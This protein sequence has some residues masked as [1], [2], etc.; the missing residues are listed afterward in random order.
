NTRVVATGKVL[1]S[2][3]PF[4]KSIDNE[5]PIANTLGRREADDGFYLFR[6]PNK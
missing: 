3:S 1:G 4:C 6:N 5:Y 2:I